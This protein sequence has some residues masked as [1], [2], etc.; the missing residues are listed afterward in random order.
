MSVELKGRIIS[1]DQ[2]R[3][4]GRRVGERECIDATVFCRLRFHDRF[5]EQLS[6]SDNRSYP[7]A[8]SPPS[9]FNQMAK[10]RYTDFSR[11][12]LLKKIKQLEK[13]RYGLVW[14]D[15]IEEVAEQC[16]RQLPVLVHQPDRDIAEDPEGPTNFLIEGDNYHALFAL[17]FT[18]RRKID[19]IY[20]D[21]PYNT[22]ARDWKYNND[23]VDI[24]D[25]WRHSKWLSM[26][27]KRLLLSR[28]LLKETGVFVCSIDHYELF[29]VGM[30]L[31]EVFGE[32]NRIGI[33][34]VV[35]KPEGRNQAK[36]LGNSHEYMIFYAK[37][38]DRCRFRKVL[39]SE[40][41]ENRFDLVDDL[42]SY[43]LKNFIRLSDGKYSLRANK[44]HFWYPIYVSPD[45]KELSLEKKE[46]YAE[47]FPI[48]E[49]GQERTWKTTKETFSQRA[50]DGD[51]V[52]ERVNGRIVISEKLRESEVV[53]THWI[54]KRY[55]AYHYGTK[56]VEKILGANKF[57]FPKS[58]HLIVDMLKITAERDAVVLDYFAGSGTTGHALLELNKQ[59]DGRRKFILCTN[60]EN[61]ICNEV[62]YPR[63]SGVI[64]GYPGALGTPA[65]LKSF[66]T[67][68]V[69]NVITDNDKRVLVERSTELLCIAE[70]TFD[71]V[72]TSKVKGEYAIF[73][74]SKR[75]TAIVFDE[76]SIADCIKELNTLSLKG[77]TTIYVFS[78]DDEYNPEEFTALKTR[79]K[80][81]PIPEVILNVYRRNARLRKR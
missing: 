41:S 56:L 9:I 74:N 44:P 25:R 19:V 62:T 6:I 68:F 37:D 31:D 76:D 16:E 55:H 47:V 49:S 4:K 7:I 24:N 13:K 54:D 70:D 28:G 40:E 11:E 80:V 20:I 51:V 61:D 71:L 10:Y 29:G 66:S 81:K 78:Y 39:L 34:A 42:G 43:R 27:N 1:G 72:A 17:N 53:K 46:G 64:R 57:E 59:D 15:K 58:L 69:P 60:N 36:F 38:K 77:M 73:R 12:Q 23:Y 3:I 8:V 35:H 14:E 79:F 75:S 45:L 50:S 21:P 18:H 32:R 33:V 63:L 2:L 48:P 5:A 67:T 65:N 26:M 30:L 52:A 22:G